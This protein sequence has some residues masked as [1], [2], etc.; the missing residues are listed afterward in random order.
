MVKSV[1]IKWYE[2]WQAFMVRALLAFG[3]VYVYAS[4][5]I[6]TG[7]LL[8]YFFC[9]V[10]LVLAIKFTVQTVKKFRHGDRH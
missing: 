2:T 8:Q 4:L 1:A 3:L 6:D 9:L 7:S 5:A 10:F